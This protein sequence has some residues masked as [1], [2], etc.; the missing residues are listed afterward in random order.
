MNDYFWKVKFYD[1]IEK[2]L[3]ISTKY[4]GIR[5]VETFERI[6]GKINLS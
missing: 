6:F 4:G 3:F 5:D 1:D 2:P